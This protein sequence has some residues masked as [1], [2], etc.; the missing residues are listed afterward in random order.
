MW[1]LA[2]SGAIGHYNGDIMALIELSARQ[3]GNHPIVLNTKS[4]VSVT[5]GKKTEINPI[6]ALVY[7][8][9]IR[10]KITFVEKDKA[11]LQ[12]CNERQLEW[13]RTEFKVKGSAKKIL[14]KMFPTVSLKKKLM[15]VIKNK[16]EPTKKSSKT[17]KEN[18]K[19]REG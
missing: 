3:V 8:G 13:L 15:P 9:D 18:S 2:P 16:A 10:F 4:K 11:K 1:P 6:E 12:T 5:Y 7:L 14:N 19:E 17:T